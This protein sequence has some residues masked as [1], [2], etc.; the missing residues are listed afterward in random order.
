MLVIIHML[1]EFPYIIFVT[2][3]ELLLRSP[4]FNLSTFK[5]V[6]LSLLVSVTVLKPLDEWKYNFQ[7]LIFIGYERVFFL[8]VLVEF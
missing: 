4:H 7:F 3:C 5:A 8:I 2:D 1:F 6:K